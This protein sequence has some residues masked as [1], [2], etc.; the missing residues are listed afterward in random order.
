MFWNSKPKECKETKKSKYCEIKKG[1][2]IHEI[3][4]KD[5]GKQIKVTRR[6]PSASISETKFFDKRKEAED[7]FKNLKK[8]I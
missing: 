1:R 8:S 2:T 6:V 3:S 4:L 7:Y 5:L